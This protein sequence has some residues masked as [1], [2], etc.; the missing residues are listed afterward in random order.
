M[1]KPLET[2]QTSLT[3]VSHIFL[4][5]HLGITDGC[6]L[7]F[8]LFGQPLHPSAGAPSDKGFSKKSHHLDLSELFSGDGS[9]STSIKKNW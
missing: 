7:V 6:E 1:G 2:T 3:L 5:A 4:V 9:V 8:E